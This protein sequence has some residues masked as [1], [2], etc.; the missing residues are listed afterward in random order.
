MLP[1]TMVLLG[2]TSCRA[3]RRRR[4]RGGPQLRIMEAH[5][6]EDHYQVTIILAHLANAHGVLANPR[7]KKDMLERALRIKEAHYGEDHYKT[8]IDQKNILDG[9][10][11]LP[12][13]VMA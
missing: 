13:N 12:V 1:R 11:V 3:F 5:Y 10:R 9:L 8:C 2:T 6:G 4:L 7:T